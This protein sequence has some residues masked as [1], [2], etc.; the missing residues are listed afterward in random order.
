MYWTDL[1]T[2]T[3]PVTVNSGCKF[4]PCLNGGRCVDG[5]KYSCD[6]S[7]EFTGESCE[8]G[9]DVM[10]YSCTIVSK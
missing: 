10:T 2:T 3:F 6:C 7:P 5:E 4:N 1:R 8:T 9:G